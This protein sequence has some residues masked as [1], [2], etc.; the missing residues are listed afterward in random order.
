MQTYANLGGDSGV[1]KYEIGQNYIDVEFKDR[2]KD[3]CNTY[4]YTYASA[5][6]SNIEQ[7]KQL[8]AAGRGLH[9][10]I[11]LNVKKDYESKW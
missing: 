4:K 7:M 5:G 2:N 1:V 11:M 9:S 10:F 3:G 6:A 8:A